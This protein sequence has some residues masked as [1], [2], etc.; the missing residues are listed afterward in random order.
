[1]LGANHQVHLQNKSSN[2]LKKRSMFKMAILHKKAH[3]YLSSSD[4]L[5]NTVLINTV[6]STRN[7]KAIFSVLKF[8]I[9]I[10]SISTGVI[11]NLVV[12]F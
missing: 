11:S 7:F 3:Q 9:F 5:E 6:L 8:D 12:M 1:M 4:A 10:W 2:R